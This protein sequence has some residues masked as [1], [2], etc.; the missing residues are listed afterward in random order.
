MGRT[1][2]N[3]EIIILAYQWSIGIEL[4]IQIRINLIFSD[5]IDTLEKK[6]EKIPLITLTYYAPD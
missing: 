1:D 4:F 3:L 5:L 6:N 2:D